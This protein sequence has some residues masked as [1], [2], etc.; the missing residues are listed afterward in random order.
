M[1]TSD[2]KESA[3]VNAMILSQGL[4]LNSV[5]FLEHTF[6]INDLLNK[7][8]MLMLDIYQMNLIYFDK[9]Y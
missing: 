2:A 9:K 8:L 3:S 6:D 1:I 5:N 4:N 7:K